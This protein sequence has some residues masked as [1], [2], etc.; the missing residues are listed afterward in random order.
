MCQTT[1]TRWCGPVNYLCLHLIRFFP[2]RRITCNSL[3]R[4]CHIRLV[5][6]WQ[7]H[8]WAAMNICK[9]ECDNQ[10]G[11]KHGSLAYDSF[12]TSAFTRLDHRDTGF[13]KS[14]SL[15]AN[16]RC[17]LFGALDGAHGSGA[18]NKPRSSC[19]PNLEPHQAFWAKYLTAAFYICLFT[20]YV[21]R[22]TPQGVRQLCLQSDQV[23]RNLQ[24]LENKLNQNLLRVLVQIVDTIILVTPMRTPMHLNHIAN[25]RTLSHRTLNPLTLSPLT[26]SLLTLSRQILM[27]LRM[28]PP[29]LIT[30]RL[31]TQLRMKLPTLT[32]LTTSHLIIHLHMKLPTL[33]IQ[34]IHSLTIHLPR[35][36][37]PF[38]IHHKANRLRLFPMAFLNT[39]TRHW[40]GPETKWR[41]IVMSG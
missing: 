26:L 31:T 1:I 10:R 27:Q 35:N 30:S 5:T 23:R 41:L 14:D 12:Y 11:D 9:L 7:A 2:Q 19:S 16:M 22:P 36:L 38:T 20:N 21:Y 4:H 32:R 18:V 3:D 13:Q 29:I 40:C 15:V 8:G 6:R 24:S 34:I 28:K 33:M 37:L 39:S 17:A 25:H